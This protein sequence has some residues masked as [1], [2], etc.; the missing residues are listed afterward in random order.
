[1]H[2][3]ISLYILIITTSCALKQN[4]SELEA[5][6]TIDHYQHYQCQK[7]FDSIS[8]PTYLEIWFDKYHKL[9]SFKTNYPT[10]L[11]NKVSETILEEEDESSEL[12]LDE[13]TEK[14]DFELKALVPPNEVNINL[15]DTY[16]FEK[17]FSND[18][19]NKAITL[20]YRISTAGTDCKQTRVMK[21]DNWRN[22]Y[23]PSRSAILL[24]EGCTSKEEVRYIDGEKSSVSESRSEKTYFKC[25]VSK[26]DSLPTSKENSIQVEKSKLSD[27]DENT[28]VTAISDIL[29]DREPDFPAEFAD[30]VASQF[31]KS[32]KLVESK[33]LYGSE[34][35][36][37]MLQHYKFDLRAS[38]DEYSDFFLGDSSRVDSYPE[39]NDTSVL[40]NL[41]YQKS[42]DTNKFQVVPKF[43]SCRFD[44]KDF[45]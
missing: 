33:K 44:H 43:S 40:C 1:M 29:K 14:E 41:R 9:V 26:S 6:Q 10:L 15:G 35:F 7:S 36:V 12:D 18:I 16:I 11:K 39:K 34:S 28:L 38:Y 4:R 17:L 20:N 19:E 45:D 23:Q 31:F 13:T 5:V 42:T 27:I 21:L 22:Q 37:Q 2:R 32:K 25:M 8:K 30:S 24:M 3:L